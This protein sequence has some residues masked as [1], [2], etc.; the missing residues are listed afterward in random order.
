M[1][2]P[3]LAALQQHAQ[4]CFDAAKKVAE[5]INLA[6]FNTFTEAKS[7]LAVKIGPR[8]MYIAMHT[9]LPTMLRIVEE[10]KGIVVGLRGDGAIA[11]F[12]LVQAGDDQPR[13]TSE[14]A[15]NAVRKACDCGD[16]MVKAMQKVV[17]PVLQYGKIM[18]GDGLIGVGIDVGEIVA[19]RIGIGE[20]H[21]LTAYGTAVN[22]CCKRSCGNDL[23]IL[24]KHAKKM[25]P[26]SKGGK[27]RFRPYLDKP[28]A[29]ILRYPAD[30]HVL[31]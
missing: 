27:T 7:Q 19:T 25:F 30:Y 9:Y 28:D 23:V 10:F 21:E 16:V 3:S 20:A 8:N 11:C 17:N 31:A 29:F 22:T 5:E 26:K 1:P 6:T 14:Q 12:G 24:T 15:E 18:S 4:Q 2:M 13:V